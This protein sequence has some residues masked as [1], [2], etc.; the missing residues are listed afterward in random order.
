M[1]RLYAL[2]DNSGVQSLWRVSNA[3][4]NGVMH[5][6]MR[7]ELQ[8]SSSGAQCINLMSLIYSKSSGVEVTSSCKTNLLGQYSPPA[9]G[10]ESAG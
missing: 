7:T 6:F 1:S 10:R 5:I 4:A 3:R 2:W 8:D 9:S